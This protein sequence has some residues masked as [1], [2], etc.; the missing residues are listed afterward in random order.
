MVFFDKR[1]TGVS[2][3]KVEFLYFEGVRQMIDEMDFG[4]DKNVTSFSD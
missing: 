4:K 1:T 3:E 2:H